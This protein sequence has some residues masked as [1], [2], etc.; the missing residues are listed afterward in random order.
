MGRHYEKSDLAAHALGLDVIAKTEIDS[1]P[2]SS[3]LVVA[4]AWQV[5][6]VLSVSELRGLRHARKYARYIILI[7]L[8]VVNKDC[9][10]NLARLSRQ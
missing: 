7:N 5:L 4:L 3:L 6:A 10:T 9:P 8:S 2:V 1:Y